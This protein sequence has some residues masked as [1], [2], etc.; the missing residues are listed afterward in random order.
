MDLVHSADG[1]E[2]VDAAWALRCLCKGDEAARRE[3]AA[4]LPAVSEALHHCQPAV[5]MQAAWMMELLAREEGN[6]DSMTLSPALQSLVEVL[7]HEAAAGAAAGA[8]VHSAALHAGAPAHAAHGATHGAAH[9]AHRA[10]PHGL[11]HAPAHAAMHEAGA[12]THALRALCCLA[13]DS[14]RRCGALIA[15]GVL[16]VA[17]EHLQ[18][19]GLPGGAAVILLRHLAC[20]LPAALSTEPGADGGAPNCRTVVAGDER[21]IFGLVSAL[22]WCK[23]P[24]ALVASLEALGALAEL[25]DDVGRKIAEAGAMPSL[26]Y[27][28]HYSSASVASAAAEAIAAWPPAATASRSDAMSEATSSVD[29]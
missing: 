29:L 1:R 6:R 18:A 26:M 5:V 24:L 22:E 20:A 23:D 9:S 12:A 13:E 21:V 16:P 17:V 7:K 27:L 15:A 3:I 11:P 14:R 10:P 25:N 28:S 4:N 8:H 2:A 19:R